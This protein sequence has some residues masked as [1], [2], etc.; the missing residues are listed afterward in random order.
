M[1]AFKIKGIIK[2][3]QCINPKTLDACE[4]MWIATLFDVGVI[5]YYCDVEEKEVLSP[6]GKQ[7]CKHS[8]YKGRIK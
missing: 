5:P 2:S 8:E 3:R 6:D 7:K 4:H 1:T